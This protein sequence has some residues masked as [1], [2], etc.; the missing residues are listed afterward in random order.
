MRLDIND[1]LAIPTHKLADD[2]DQTE[3]GLSDAEN[4]RAAVWNK[5]ED[6]RHGLINLSTDDYVAEKIKLGNLDREISDLKYEIAILRD[7]YERLILVRDMKVT[8][9]APTPERLY[10]L[11]RQ[12]SAAFQ[13][14]TEIRAA[15]PDFATLREVVDADLTYYTAR[16]R[17]DASRRLFNKAMRAARS[18]GKS[19]RVHP[20][21]PQVVN[22]YVKTGRFKLV[23]GV[24]VPVVET[25]S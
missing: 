20:Q 4:R 17:F 1:I 7:R 25:V 15:R 3:R 22:G 18:A 10:D 8:T 24:R 11:D 23:N 12:V 2:F 13:R 21:R 5:I 14:R 19:F 6:A 16:W 9:R